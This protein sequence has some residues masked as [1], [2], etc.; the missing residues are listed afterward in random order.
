MFDGPLEIHLEQ[1]RVAGV[2]KCCDARNTGDY[3][4]VLKV[5]ASF[6]E[7]LARFIGSGKDGVPVLLE[8]DEEKRLARLALLDR[9]FSQFNWFADFTRISTR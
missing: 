7:P 1:C 8:K 2:T 6:E 4:T 9:I 5:M 3:A